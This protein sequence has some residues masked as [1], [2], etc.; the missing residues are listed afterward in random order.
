MDASAGCGPAVHDGKCAMH[1]LGIQVLPSPNMTATMG[2]EVAMLSIGSEDMLAYYT[3][4]AFATGF[5]KSLAFRLRGIKQNRGPSCEGIWTTKRQPGSSCTSPDVEA[6]MRSKDTLCKVVMLSIGLEDMLAHFTV[7]AAFKKMQAFQPR[8]IK[9]S[10][11]SSGEGIWI[12]TR[13][14]K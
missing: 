8:G 11:G 6:L 9:Q 12:T 7:A 10:R 13:L 2:C 1:K 3:A 14:D 4:N 5:K